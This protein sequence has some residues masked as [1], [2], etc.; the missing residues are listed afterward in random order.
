MEEFVRRNSRRSTRR[1]REQAGASPPAALIEHQDWPKLCAVIID[2]LRRF[3]EA[4]EAVDE[5]VRKQF[6]EKKKE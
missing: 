4:H 1:R 2:A 3:P 5:A 6:R